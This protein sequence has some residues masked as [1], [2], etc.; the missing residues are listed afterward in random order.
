LNL[1]QLYALG[2][3]VPRDEGAAF[4]WFLKAASQG[5]SGAQAVVGFWYAQGIGTNKDLISAC[6]WLLAARQQGDEEGVETLQAIEAQL[7]MSQR[8]ESKK[9]TQ[10][11]VVSRHETTPKAVLFY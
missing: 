7:N 10:S 1:G 3:G 5:H 9:R 11:L 8:I 2:E 6:A 4:A